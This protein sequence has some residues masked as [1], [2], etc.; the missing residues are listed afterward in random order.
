MKVTAQCLE[1]TAALH[2]DYRRNLIVP[3][4]SYGMGIGYEADLVI[5]SKSHYATEIEIKISIYDLR[6]DLKK[7]KF[8]PYLNW[9]NRFRQF[10][11]LIPEEMLKYQDEI[12]NIILPSA[13]LMVRKHR[14]VEDRYTGKISLEYYI[15]TVRAAKINT[16]AMKLSDIEYLHLCHLA[17][18]RI[19]TLKIHLRKARKKNEHKS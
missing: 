6:N 13:G 2:F 14:V 12:L 10:Y 3:N 19:W 15:E 18:M 1:I 9:L 7:R 8:H 4:V 16:K 11:Y 5:V 17:A